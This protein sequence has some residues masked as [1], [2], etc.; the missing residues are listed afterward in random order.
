MLEVIREK[1]LPVKKVVVASSQ[2]FTAKGPAIV[3]NMD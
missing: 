2:L 3:R 1:A